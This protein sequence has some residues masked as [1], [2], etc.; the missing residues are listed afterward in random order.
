VP[1]P[2][3]FAHHSAIDWR[4]TG[5]LGLT[6]LV[7]GYNW[8]QVKIGVA[9]APPFAFAAMR[10]L[11][12]A[13]VLFAVMI[14]G[15]QRMVSGPLWPTALVGLFQTAGF[16]GLTTWAVVDAGVGQVAVLG[17]SMPL[18]VPLAAWPLLGQRVRPLETTAMLLGIAGFACMVGPTSFTDAGTAWRG[19]V[20]ALLGAVSWAVGVVLAKCLQQRE[21]PDLASFTAWQ[22]L[23][24]SLPLAAAALALP[25]RPIGWTP[26][27]LIALGYNGVLATAL[28]FLLFMFAVRRLPVSIAGLGNLVVPL[29]GVA[30]AWAQFGERPAT[31][32]VIGILLLVGA[33]VIMTRAAAH[34]EGV[35]GIT[36]ATSSDQASPSL[37]AAAASRAS[38]D[39]TVSSGISL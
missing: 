23:F 30:A 29:I 20:L 31:F 17:N 34:T 33:L 37:L 38:K 32:E 14:A 16:F 15:R 39:R 18:W 22:M 26:P 3:R 7:W 8:V 24:G 9:Y 35:H 5:A 10:G 2:R 27:F 36:P 19:D 12:G 25:G 28:A 11:L 21:K 1:A 13:A 4:A 6:T